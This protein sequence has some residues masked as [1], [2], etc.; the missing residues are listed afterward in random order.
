MTEINHRK[1][2][3]PIHSIFLERWSPRAFTGE[4][5]GEKDLLAL[6][7]AAR[8]APSA[9]NLQPWRFV[10]ARRGTGHFARL[11]STLD[12]GNQRWAKNASALV[13]ILSKTHRTTSTGEV[14]PAY[15][16]AF[17]TGAAWFALALQTQLSGWHAHAMAGVDREKAIQVLGVPEHYRVEA[18]VAIGRIADPST[19]PDDLREREKPSQR[20]PFSE[21][22]FEGHFKGE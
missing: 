20:R 6:F 17:D 15:T 22:V 18:A 2:D 9:S 11:L 10:Y 14:R 8:W 3:H 16:H 7:E 19:L 21:F 5:I 12:E 13:I 4:E 1:A